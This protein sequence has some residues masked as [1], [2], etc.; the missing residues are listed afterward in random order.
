MAIHTFVC[1]DCGKEFSIEIPFGNSV[2]GN[3]CPDCKSEN[4]KKIFYP[5]VITFKGSGFYKTDN[6]KEK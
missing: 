2:I 5:P 6:R 4:I 1:K 3:F